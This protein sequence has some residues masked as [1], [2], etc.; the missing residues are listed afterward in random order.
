M[1]S[2]GG[3]HPKW[4]NLSSW[5]P[6]FLGSSHSLDAAEDAAEDSTQDAPQ[7]AAQDAAQDSTQDAVEDAA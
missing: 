2:S 7:D 5:F 4:C 1:D 6:Y 3:W